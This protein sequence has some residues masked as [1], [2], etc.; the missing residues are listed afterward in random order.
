MRIRAIALLI[1]ALLVLGVFSLIVGSAGH[2]PLDVLRTLATSG[3]ASRYA[4]IESVVKAIPI[5]LCAIAAGIPG[6]LGLVNIGGEGQLLAGAIGA[7]FAVNLAGSSPLTLLL[8]AVFGALAG[9]AWAMLPGALRGFT[10]ANETV[11]SLLLNYVAGLLLLHLI[12]GPWKDPGGL[13][14]PQTAALPDE[15]RLA[16]LF[17]TR[18]HSLVFYAVGAAALLAFAGRRS[19]LGMAARII[20]SNPAAAAYAGLPVGW[21]YALAFAAGGLMAGLGGFGELSGIQGRL[22]DGMSLG[23]GYAGFFVAWLCRNR[24]EWMPAAALLFAAV[25]TGAD[26]LQLFSGLPFATVYLLQGLLFLG[27]LGYPSVMSRLGART[28]AESTP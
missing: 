20:E 11:I 5:L 17:G 27:L 2:N 14:W 19:I 22:R 13:G 10:K 1:V 23:Y 24:F 6:R 18:I 7:M 21:Y 15:A 26:S 4:L 12:H 25:I 8:M 9:G 28:E 3:F 16:G